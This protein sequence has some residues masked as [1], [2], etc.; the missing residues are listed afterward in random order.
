MLCICKRK[1]SGSLTLNISDTRCVEFSHTSQFPNSLDTNWVS[2]ISI[3]TLTI[4]S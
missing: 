2:Y 1:T 3:M 4:R